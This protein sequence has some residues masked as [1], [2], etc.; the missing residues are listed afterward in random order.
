MSTPLLYD[1]CEREFKVTEDTEDVWAFDVGEAEVCLD[2]CCVWAIVLRGTYRV[3]ETKTRSSSGSTSMSPTSAVWYLR[4]GE[5]GK[6][7]LHVVRPSAV[8]D[9]TSRVPMF[10]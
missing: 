8:V 7:Q 10:R 5:S 4:Y 3:L 9:T 6:L 2:V 1:S